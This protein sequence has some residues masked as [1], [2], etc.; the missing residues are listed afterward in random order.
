MRSIILSGRLT[1]DPEIREVTEKKTKVAE[2]TL[3]NNDRDKENAEFFDVTCW[4]TLAKFVENYVK[5]GQKI[6]VSGSFENE[7]Y[8]DKDGNNRYHF[9]IK[10]TNI[11]FAG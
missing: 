5:K 7:A 6:V 2:F 10:A 4:D 9:R 3:A 11:E 8:K 1:R